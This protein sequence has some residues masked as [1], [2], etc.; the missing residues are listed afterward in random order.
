MTRRYGVIVV[1]VGA[2]GSAACYHIAKR[3]VPVLG[4]DRFDI[5]NARGSS[6]GLS[7]VIR[8]AYFEHPDY[9]PLLERAYT[10]WEELEA[11]SKQK[12][13]YRTGGIY[14]GRPES[15]A[16]AGS[17]RAI[18]EHGLKHEQ[19]SHAQLAQH[20]PQF[21]VPKD[22]VGLFEEATGFLLPERC[23]AAYAEA[24]LRRGAEL[25]GHERVTRWDEDDSGASVVTDR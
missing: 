8:K 14:M 20:Y 24:A 15:E 9:V 11:V 25:H 17:L 21:V 12:L 7:R 1:G 5:P 22:Y 4:I 6:H 10:N 19:F 23:I 2:M 16:I 18:R 3:G 13:L